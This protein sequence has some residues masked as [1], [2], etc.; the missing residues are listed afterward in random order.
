MD[1]DALRCTRTYPSDLDGSTLSGSPRR[2]AIVRVV[3][4]LE[5]TV[6]PSRHFGRIRS[7][8]MITIADL[9]AIAALRIHAVDAANSIPAR[10]DSYLGLSDLEQHVLTD[11]L[12][13]L[14]SSPFIRRS[15]VRK[16]D[17]S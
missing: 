4:L 5:S 10:R 16:L 2:V 11:L 14:Q 3:A 1:F 12:S 13:E 8:T 17:L 7:L 9:R 15:L 6:R